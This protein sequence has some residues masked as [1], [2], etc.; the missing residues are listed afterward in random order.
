MADEEKAEARSLRDAEEA[1]GIVG[2][3]APASGLASESGEDVQVVQPA[4]GDIL[5]GPLASLESPEE[6]H[7]EAG[8]VFEMSKDERGVGSAAAVA[9]VPINASSTF[10]GRDALLAA[11]D[12]GRL[13]PGNLDAILRADFAGTPMPGDAQLLSK[14]D[15]DAIKAEFTSGLDFQK[16]TGEGT[17]FVGED[18][19]SFKH[20]DEINPNIP[21]DE[22]A[23]AAA[24][25]SAKR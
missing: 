20:E 2:T 1:A 24:G 9:K 11:T 19:N 12:G 6:A 5:S 25:R 13:M 10:P 7:I 23:R 22:V 21:T 16:D 18:P 3:N 8:K 14:S 15:I 4:E 17:R